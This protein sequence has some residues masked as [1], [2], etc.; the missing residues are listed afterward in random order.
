MVTAFAPPSASTPIPI[1]RASHQLGCPTKLLLQNDGD[2]TDAT[3]TSAKNS[4]SDVKDS[5]EVTA[6]GSTEYYQG[7]ITRSVNEE[8]NERVTG[9]AVLGPTLKFAGGISL[10]LVVLT[11]AFLVS[12]GII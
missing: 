7:F 11:A 1:L 8:P 6:V 2:A 9:D 4:N 10:I 3:D 12:N 5:S